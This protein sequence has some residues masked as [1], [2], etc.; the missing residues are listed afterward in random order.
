VSPRPQIQALSAGVDLVI[1]TPGRLLDHL[2][3]RAIDLSRIETL[4]LD[5][6][7]RMLDMGFIRAIRR[8]IAA[9]PKQRQNLMFSAT[10]PDDIRTPREVRWLREPGQSSMSQ[11]RN[12]APAELVDHQ[13]LSRRQRWQAPAAHASAGRRGYASSRWSSRAPSTAP[14][15][16]QNAWRAMDW[17]VSRSTATNRRRRARVPRAISS[18]AVCACWSPP[19]S[20]RADWTSANCR[21]S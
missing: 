6:A 19:T 10:L 21:T 12:S 11:P 17:P 5:E 15:A 13:R 4:V 20:P 9:L 7:D 1:A 14:T 16:W 3:G 8:I 2:Q 18:K